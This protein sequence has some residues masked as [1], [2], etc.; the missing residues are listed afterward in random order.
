MFLLVVRCMRYGSS[1][2]QECLSNSVFMFVSSSKFVFA[3]TVDARVTSI[4]N[5][6]AQTSCCL[7]SRF[8][9]I[10]WRPISLLQWKLVERWAVFRSSSSGVIM[11]HRLAKSWSI[12]YTI[13]RLL[14]CVLVHCKK[15]ISP[16]PS[17]SFCL[18]HRQGDGDRAC[19]SVKLAS[20]LTLPCQWHSHFL[21]TDNIW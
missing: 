1:T 10:S 12:F 17:V 6:I 11:V 9:C 3:L 21:L 16:S 19:P 14:P 7:C 4:E 20:Q 15:V 18:S 8:T 5:N 13:M 2:R